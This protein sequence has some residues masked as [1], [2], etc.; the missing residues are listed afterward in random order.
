MMPAAPLDDA[1][2]SGGTA[3]AG[4]GDSLVDAIFSDGWD[5]PLLG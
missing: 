5:N 4:D 3:S 2:A 1:P